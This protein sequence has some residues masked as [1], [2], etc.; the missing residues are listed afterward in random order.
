VRIRLKDDRIL[1]GTA[2]QIVAQMRSLALFCQATTLDGYIEFV[3]D[4]TL[5]FENVLLR[6]EGDTED[7]RAESLV[8]ELIRT[9]LAEEL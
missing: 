5:R 9:G 2:A 3:I 6:V 7:Q 8:S 1:Q 4:A